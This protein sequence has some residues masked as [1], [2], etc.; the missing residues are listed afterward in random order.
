[1]AHHRQKTILSIAGAILVSALALIAKDLVRSLPVATNIVSSFSFQT[2]TGP[3][4]AMSSSSA[5][6][7]TI[8]RVVDGD[9]VE[10]EDGN[11]VRYIGV[12]TPETHHPTKGVQCYGR[13]AAAFNQSLVEGK[14]VRLEKDVSETDRY[15]RLLRFV[16]LED[17]TFVNQVLLE[18]GY[19]QVVTYPPDIAK[20][21]QFLAVQAE[22]REEKKGLWGYCSSTNF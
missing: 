8:K 16:Y 13:E 1:M 17:G 18:K 2:T 21:K 4:S 3:Q 5:T 20:S 11:K 9:T 12:N 14:L 6:W 10:L 19:A 7:Y 22:A 15:G